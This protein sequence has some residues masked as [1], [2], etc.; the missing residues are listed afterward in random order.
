MASLFCDTNI[1]IDLVESRGTIT[2]SDLENHELFISPLSIHIT[3]Y[4]Y[5]HTV[6]Y[7]IINEMVKD[8]IELVPFTES[9]T[10]KA[11]E[12]PTRDFE[13]NVQLHSGVST[14]CDYFL[15]NDTSLLKMAYFGKMKIVDTLI[16]KS[17]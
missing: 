11:L 4:S 10:L 15:T 9:I 2:L 3:C 14:D 7:L 12:G 16:E 1:F 8:Y 13:D 6:P 17:S 5:K